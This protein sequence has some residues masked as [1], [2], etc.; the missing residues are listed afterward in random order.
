MGA[1]AT[2]AMMALPA[3]EGSV[4]GDAS[5]HRKFYTLTA[6]LREIYDDNVNTVKSNPQ[7]SF[8]TELTPSILVDFPTEK[9]DFSARCTLGITYYS[10]GTNNGGSNVNGGKNPSEIRLSDEFLAQYTHSFSDRFNLS[11]A[12]SLRYY[13]EPSIDQSTGTNYQNGDYIANI[14]NGV[15]T[16]QWTPL[17]GTSSN[18]SN[19]VVRYD[20]SAVGQAQNSV[21]NTGTQSISYAIL[22]KV[23][24][25]VGGIVDEITYDSG[26]RGYTTY[27]GFAG[28]SWQ[29]LPSLS[30]SGRGGAT[31]I[32]PVQGKDNIAPY[33]AM[34]IAW[35][36]GAR[37]SLAFNYAHEVTP[38]DQVGAN[39][40]TSDRFTGN[41]KYD[42]TTRLSS[43]LQG[44]FTYSTIS[45]DLSTSGGAGL[46]QQENQY[47][48]DTGFVYQYNSYLNLDAGITI[49]GVTSE[50]STLE[51][52]RDEVYLGVRG[53]Y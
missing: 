39:G 36:L 26:I 7:A 6:E 37:S 52:G 18:F 29:I 24:V 41:F 42:I 53:T 8:E 33:A 28:A 20:N 50:V 30:A 5:T 23:S 10:T 16:A 14:F 44:T 19:T 12:E 31:Y 4:P 27:T 15:L 35:T 49:S 34:T 25:S 32:V 47:Y 17:V 46:S 3:N 13:T 48:L 40:Q 51:Y 38:S 1:S 2:P 43:Y 11:L 9:G 21:E 45:Q 22:P